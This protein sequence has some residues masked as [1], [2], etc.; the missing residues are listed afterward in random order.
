MDR[1]IKCLGSAALLLASVPV[2]AAEIFVVDSPPVGTSEDKTLKIW[3]LGAVPGVDL[4]KLTGNL[5]TGWGLNWWD[6]DSFG[7]W[8][9]SGNEFIGGMSYDLNPGEHDQQL[10]IYDS[11][12]GFNLGNYF[13]RAD[14]KLV[15][16]VYV[17]T[18]RL[19]VW[20]DQFRCGEIPEEERV[21]SWNC[22]IRPFGGNWSGFLIVEGP[23]EGIV[24]F[25][26]WFGTTV[27]EPATWAMM[28]GGFGLVGAGLRVRRRRA[29]STRA[30]L[31][32]TA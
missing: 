12:Y 29:A 17:A 6:F 31:G 14:L 15:D 10:E 24:Q 4:I 26:T 32:I 2:S 8:Y 25:R 18:L 1:L 30:L 13:A 19:A 11:A 3:V 5:D 28:I 16:D 27:P 23:N 21:V 9:V 20:P 7:N 22:G